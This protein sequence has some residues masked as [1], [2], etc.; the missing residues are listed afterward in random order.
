MAIED[1]IATGNPV[2]LRHQDAV[3]LYRKCFELD[4]MLPVF[5]I[6]ALSLNKLNQASRATA[7]SARR[8]QAASKVAIRN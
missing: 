2:P 8:M 5:G 6:A 7:L 1:L 3:R 4:W